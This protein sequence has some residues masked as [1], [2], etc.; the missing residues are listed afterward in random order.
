M[1]FYTRLASKNRGDA[2]RRR[3][4]ERLI[5]LRASLAKHLKESG[6]AGDRSKSVRICTWNLRE[7]GGNKH[8]GRDY[9]SLYYIAE[10]LSQ[11]DIVALQEVRQDLEEFNTLLKILGPDWDYLASDV[12][13][14]HSGNGERMVFL[15]NQKKAFFRHIAGEL[16]LPGG[17][18][19]P[20]SFGERVLLKNGCTLLLPENTDLSGEYKARTKTSGSKVK[21]DR[22]LEIK[23]PRG[24]ALSLPEGC[25]LSVQKN[26]LI[27]RPKTGMAALEFPGTAIESTASQ[28]YGVRFPGGSIDDSFKQFAR[29]PYIVSFQAGWLKLVFCTVHIYFG[30]NDD[31]R[32]LEQRKAEIRALTTSLGDRA[33]QEY[34]EDPE[35]RTLMGVLG[36]FN[37][38]SKTHETMAAL[39][40]NGFIVP[41][42][43]KKIPG[44]NVKKDRTYDQIA[45]WEPDRSR[46]YA[47]LDILAAGVFDFF[48]EVYR[49]SDAPVYKAEMG[50]TRSSFDTWRTYKMSDHLPMWV[51]LR[52]DFSDEYL[53]RCGDTP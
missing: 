1:P 46:G 2:K 8:G 38:I 3:T 44:S 19:I 17:A 36:D 29:S 18:K 41:K 49:H 9:E 52:T 20:A 23:L 32:L 35:N 15:F 25:A 31:P 37:I 28:E 6:S 14:G 5:A 51:E 40:N 27:E 45:F 34:E 11:F 22:D 13:P 21:L 7:F 48:Q 30:D 10:I 39:E 26:S 42:E 33:R 47:R 43:L 50:A 12:T 16:T 4:V 53:E 24:C